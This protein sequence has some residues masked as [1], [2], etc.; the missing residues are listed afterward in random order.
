[1][2]NVVGGKVERC[3]MKKTFSH[4]FN[5]LFR[6]RPRRRRTNLAVQFVCFSARLDMTLFD[7]VRTLGTIAR[8]CRVLHSIRDRAISIGKR[9]CEG[10][11]QN[12]QRI[13]NETICSSVDGRDVRFLP[14]LFRSRRHFVDCLP[15]LSNAVQRDTHDQ[16]QA[17][18]PTRDVPSQT[19]HTSPAASGVLRR[20]HLV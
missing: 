14:V 19:G 18:E 8:P 12:M 17:G 4:S 15:A 16:R 13:S 10:C 7:D 11:I 1:M 5:M 2:W 6:A 3:R 20:T 9:S